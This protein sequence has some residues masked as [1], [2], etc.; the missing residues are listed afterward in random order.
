METEIGA[1]LREARNRRKVE[2]SEVEATIKI[3]ARYLRAMENEEWGALPGGAYARSFVRTYASYLGLDSERLADEVRRSLESPG[4]E[5]APRVEPIVTGGPRRAGPRLSRRAWAAI[6]SIGLVALLVGVGLVGGGDD[7]SSAPA[8]VAKQDR[9]DRAEARSG[10]V[11]TQP[12]VAVR[13]AASGE[14]WVCLLDAD[15]RPLIDG[16][17]LAPGAEAGPFRSEGFTVSFGNGEVSMLIDGREAEI[18]ATSSP[19][20]YAIDAGGELQPLTETERP[21]CG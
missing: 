1:I 2:L 5:R 9:G 4:G 15:S 21:I 16:Q 8:P 17:V 11:T 6:V 12:G 3:R 20:G 14:V 10:A 19:V 13:L 7:G 18:A